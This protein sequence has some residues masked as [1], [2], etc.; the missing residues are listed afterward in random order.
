MARLRSHVSSAFLVA[1]SAIQLLP[2]SSLASSPKFCQLLPKIQLRSHYCQ[3]SLNGIVIVSGLTIHLRH[4]RSWLVPRQR[5]R[6]S[7]LRVCLRQPCSGGSLRRGEVMPR[8]AR[9]GFR[10]SEEIDVHKSPLNM[11]WKP[12]EEL[13][14]CEESALSK[15]R[16][17]P[18]PLRGYIYAPS[19]GGKYLAMHNF[20]LAPL[21]H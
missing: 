2:S 4:P 20:R 3:S 18:K 16:S 1:S 19:G 12:C 21:L 11:Y 7:R 14:D 10:P 17:R 15:V 8:G 13:E 6:W 5:P 9:R